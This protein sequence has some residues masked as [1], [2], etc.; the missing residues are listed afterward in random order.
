MV[1]QIKFYVM[2]RW[3]KFYKHKNK[4]LSPSEGK[5]LR[6]QFRVKWVKYWTNVQVSLKE[7]CSSRATIFYLHDRLACI[8]IY[9]YAKT[10]SNTISSAVLSKTSVFWKLHWKFVFLGQTFEKFNLKNFSTNFCLFLV[11][12]LHIQLETK[13][14]LHFFQ[15]DFRFPENKKKINFL[16]F[17]ACNFHFQIKKNWE[18]LWQNASAPLSTR[19]STFWDLTRANRIKTFWDE[20]F[21]MSEN[22]QKKKGWKMHLKICHYLERTCCVVSAVIHIMRPFRLRRK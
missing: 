19:S 1:F 4:N 8:F 13:I 12:T 11:K 5:Y 14:R 21:E 18:D 9:I 20:T 7:P 3:K 16:E 17:F 10:H 2:K 22:N 15:F 6:K